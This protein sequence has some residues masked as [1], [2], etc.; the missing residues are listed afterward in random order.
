M[1]PHFTGLIA[2]PFTPMN[3]DGSVDLRRIEK[4]AASLAANGVRGAFVNGSTGESMSLTVEERLQTAERWAAV[5]PKSLAVIVHVGHTTLADCRRMAAHAQKIGARAIGA[6]PPFFFKPGTMEDLVACCAD[7]A[8]AAP[9]VPF[10]YYHIPSLTG[11]NFAMVDFLKAAAGRIPTLAGIKF[12]YENL[13]DFG[14]CVRFDGGRFNLLFG[15]DEILLSGMIA[16][17]RGAVGS[18]YSFAAPLYH[19]IIAAYDA[20]DLA[21]AQR[22]QARAADFIAIAIR[23]G[24]LPAF[25]AM[26]AMIGLDC[27]PSRLPMRTLTK[28]RAAQL[29]EELEGLGFFDYASRA[30]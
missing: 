11:V 28:E 12:T 14:Q 30:G 7:M 10:Y 17:A 3:D 24:G 27:G 19:R 9:Q 26:M 23:H 2:A 25:K 22:D 1:N 8:A 6:M 15:R 18:T 13:M 21:A 4:L 20:G 5:A 29:L 16:G